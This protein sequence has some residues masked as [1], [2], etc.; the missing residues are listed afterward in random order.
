MIHDEQTLRKNIT[1]YLYIYIFIREI[2][3]LRFK[4]H[5]LF[6]NYVLRRLNIILLSAQISYTNTDLN[7]LDSFFSETMQ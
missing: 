3:L 5:Y 6:N 2:N 4:K 7:D 1:A